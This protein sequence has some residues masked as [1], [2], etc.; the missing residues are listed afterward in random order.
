MTEPT[1]V[2]SV[3]ETKAIASL[4]EQVSK[5]LQLKDP[6][7]TISELLEHNEEKKDQNPEQNQGA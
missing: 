7:K 3:L 4:Q 2:S 1:F 5:E 6:N